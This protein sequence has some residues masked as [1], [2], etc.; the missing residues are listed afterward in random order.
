MGNCIFGGFLIKLKVL[1][2]FSFQPVKKTRDLL[3]LLNAGLGS[4]QKMALS[5]AAG[6]CLALFPVIGITAL[7]GLLAALSF[8]LNH[9]IVQTLNI[10]L[11]PL[12]IILIYPL[13]KAGNMIFAGSQVFNKI[14][15]YT[16]E[17]TFLKL[18]E[19]ITGGVLAWLILSLLTGPV[20]YFFLVRLFK[21]RE[22]M[23]APVKIDN[24]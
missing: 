15:S 22:G 13:I 3:K 10:V 18:L 14:F 11:A 1:I 7:L 23:V 20:L 2:M 21:N 4:P 19:M 17:W 5:L 6:I 16:G 8:R 24:Q 12:Q 9:M